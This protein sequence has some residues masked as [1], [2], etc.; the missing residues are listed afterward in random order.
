MNIAIIDINNEYGGGQVF[1]KNVLTKI[2]GDK[3]F[4]LK[5]NKL[6]QEI[7]GAILIKANNFLKIAKEIEDYLNKIKPDV[8]IL[9]GGFALF[10]PI[11]FRKKRKYLFYKHATY[12][13]VSSKKRLIF[14]L[15]M[16]LA[17]FYA[18]KI[19]CVSNYC[20]K[21]ELFFKKKLCVIYH[22]VNLDNNVK[23]YNHNN[24]NKLLFIYVGRIVKEKGCDLIFDYFANTKLEDRELIVV[25]DEKKSNFP[26][27][28]YKTAKNII[29]KGLQDNI[30]EIL[31]KS[32]FLITLPTNEAFGLTIIEAMANGVIV[33]ATNVG[34]IP[35]IVS[36]GNNGFLIEP[37]NLTSFLD[38]INN[39]NSFNTIQENAFLKVKSCFDINNEIESINNVIKDIL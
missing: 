10:L 15:I 33:I 29:F 11:V 26:I 20:A 30:N 22:G 19:I 39:R 35:E 24:K 17:Y 13:G 37:K 25:G 12:K 38:S 8:V 7:K 2:D 5:S 14:F 27:E 4:I 16:I 18:K 21:E 34:G 6:A 32:D 9:N 3:T 36:N 23:F 31:C 1:I 28:Q